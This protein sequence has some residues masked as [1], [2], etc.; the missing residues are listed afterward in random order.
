VQTYRI[1]Y[2]RE[3]R[4]D[5]SEL[6]PGLDLLDVIDRATE[7]ANDRT[8]EIWSENGK[9]GIVDLPSAT[10]PLLSAHP[11]VGGEAE[12]SEEMRARLRLLP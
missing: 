6:L 8:A 9:V 3:S 1:L 4:L 7:Q 11:E 12:I 5:H 10:P 2:L